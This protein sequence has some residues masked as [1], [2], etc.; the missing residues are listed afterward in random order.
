MKVIFVTNLD[1]FK[2]VCRQPYE[3]ETLPR[4]GD[5]I[6][7]EHTPDLEVYKVAHY[8]SFFSTEQ[9]IEIELHIPK[10]LKGS[11]EYPKF[12]QDNYFD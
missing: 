7:F 6:R 9:S 2:R 5:I 12:I 11:N 10:H 4:V 3:L 8:I 1:K